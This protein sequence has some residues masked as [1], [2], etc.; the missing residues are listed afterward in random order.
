MATLVD[1]AET[2]APFGGL[3]SLRNTSPT[4]SAHHFD[5][6]KYYL[7][8]VI[9]ELVTDQHLKCAIADIEKETCKRKAAP[10]WYQRVHFISY[11]KDQV[12]HPLIPI[13]P[14]TS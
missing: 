5:E 10:P 12:A 1:S 8:V 9:G 3:S 11:Q 7:L 2:P 13:L 4:A 6:G 14:I